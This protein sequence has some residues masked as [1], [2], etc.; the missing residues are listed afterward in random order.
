MKFL[1]FILVNLCAFPSYSQSAYHR[2]WSVKENRKIDILNGRTLIAENALY[3]VKDNKIN[4]TQLPEAT[5]ETFIEIG[6]QETTTIFDIYRA[7]DGIWLIVG[8]TSETE[9]FATPGSYK[10]YFDMNQSSSNPTT[11]SFVAKYSEEGE[12]HW[13]TYTDL[14]IDTT[15]YVSTVSQNITTDDDD[16]VYFISYKNNDEVIEGSPFQSAANQEDYLVP[17][18]SSTITKLNSF[19]QYQ[20]STFFGIHQTM[21]FDI[22]STNSG[23]VVAGKANH[24]IMNNTPLNTPEYFSTIG[25]YDVNPSLTSQGKLA[26]NFFINKFSFDG[27]R[28]WG[29]YM[30]DINSYGVGRI[31]TYE[32]EIFILSGSNNSSNQL[33]N[34]TTDGAFID[35]PGTIAQ[36]NILSRL[37]SNG[38]QIMWTTYINNHIFKPIE[39]SL[40]A[41]ID[42]SGNIW[43][44]G[45]TTSTTGVVT[46]DAYQTDKNM[47]NANNNDSYHLLLANDGSTVLYSSYYGFEGDD[48]SIAIFPAENSYYSVEQT[49]GNSDAENFITQGNLLEPDEEGSSTY[50]GLVYT[51]FST[52]PVSSGT[53]DKKKVSIYPNPAEN[54]LHLTGEIDDFTEVN[55]YNMQGQQVMHQPINASEIVS[56]D[57]ASIASG[58]YLLTISN[59]NNKQ[60]YRVVKK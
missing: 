44:F 7:N 6:T 38:T 16:N 27:E 11:N 9:N 51:Y 19:G 21:I 33:P 20:W 12:L 53:F 4:K 49:S 15:T 45:Q 8:S 52:E 14:Y 2:I 31:E 1:F 28:I 24:Q 18:K 17:Y 13:C 57:I 59:Q 54:V 42:N 10:E 25:G 5:T 39:S 50:G 48:A 32:D 23:I 56:V 37:S 43:L 46:E 58:V 3:T 55:I 22:K 40:N 26:L 30:G 36:Q 29:T 34:I 60:T 47:A 41:K 35:D